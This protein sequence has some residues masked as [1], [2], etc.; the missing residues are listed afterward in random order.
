MMDEL[1]FHEGRV[2]LCSRMASAVLTA[3]FAILFE[4]MSRNEQIMVNAFL[5]RM[6][7]A[8]GEFQGS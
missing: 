7:R 2:S 6:C 4:A 3:R 5:R 8:N 1:Y